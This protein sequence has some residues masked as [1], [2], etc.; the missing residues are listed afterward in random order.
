MSIHDVKEKY[1]DE[2][3]AKLKMERVPTR[4][5]Q[6]DELLGGG[7]PVGTVMTIWGGDGVGKT[8]IALEIARAF[9]NQNHY[10]VWVDVEN[11]LEQGIIEGF[12]LEEEEGHKFILHKNPVSTTDV[13][14]LLVPNEE[15]GSAYLGEDETDLVVIDSLASIKETAL[16]EGSI[17]D[18]TTANKAVEDTQLIGELST[19]ASKNDTT[20]IFLQQQR[21][22]VSA[23]MATGYDMKKS[24]GGHALKHHSHIKFKMQRKSVVNNDDGTID[25]A[26]VAFE[27]EKNKTNEIMPPTTIPI[28][29][30]KGFDEDLILWNTLSNN[31]DVLSPDI[32]EEK[33]SWKKLHLPSGDYQKQNKKEFENQVIKEHRDEIKEVLRDVGVL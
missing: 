21:A 17:K 20:I 23:S 4:S 16:V 26:E 29:Y 11:S 1:E 27:V 19:W 14:K 7:V 31:L 25:Y 2:F 28:R 22:D 15:H 6:F 3:P 5:S 32:Y 13:E 12:D 9:V 8:H 30:G 33:G 10:T 24:A 18:N